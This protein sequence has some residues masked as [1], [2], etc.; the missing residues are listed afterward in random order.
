MNAQLMHARTHTILYNIPVSLFGGVLRT[1]GDCCNE[2][3]EQGKST[4]L[5]VSTALLEAGGE[6]LLVMLFEIGMELAML[7]SS[8]SLSSNIFL[9][10][11]FLF[12]M[13]EVSTAVAIVFTLLLP[14]VL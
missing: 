11:D 10:L 6:L 3:L 1:L 8:S 13:G 12:A 5:T 2:A 7:S 4:S 9:F 14:F